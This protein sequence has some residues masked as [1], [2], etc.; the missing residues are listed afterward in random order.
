MKIILWGVRGSIPMP[1]TNADYRK[2]LVE[3]LESA[4]DYGLNDKSLITK[5]IDSLPLH[6]SHTIGGD[7]TCVEFISDSGKSYILDAGSGIRN[8]GN[9]LVASPNFT[10]NTE[11]SIFLSHNHWDHINGIPFFKP[12]YIK[13]VKIN[14]YSCY[15]N[16]EELL[17]GQMNSPYFPANFLDTASTKQFHLIGNPQ[18]SPLQLEDDLT[19]DTLELCHPDG[20]FAYRFKQN[21]KTFIF[22]TD[23]EFTGEIFETTEKKN[24]FFQEADLLLLDAQYTIEEA[25]T[26]L[27][28]GHTS[29]AMAVN[30]AINWGIK[31]L[32]LTHHNPDYSDFKLNDY[33][34][35]VEDYVEQH[36]KQLEC[37]SLNI[38]LA[39][40]G[41]S[42]EI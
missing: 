9:A 36:T 19:V 40:E 31:K 39:T 8:L 42:F 28:W 13:G 15:P 32:I 12:L 27:N 24:L 26:K 17:I 18:T 34:K 3:V 20:S 4:I 29:N 16:Q 21:G 1:L 23:A 38:S 10:P 2:K 5:F 25:F 14:F 30:C 35:D 11:I 22:C 41:M 7:T 33:L 37:S 6:I